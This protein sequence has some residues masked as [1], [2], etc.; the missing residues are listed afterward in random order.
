MTG[1]KNEPT[2]ALKVIDTELIEKAV[3]PSSEVLDVPIAWEAHPNAIPML[4]GLVTL[5]SRK[6]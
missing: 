2:T 6:N 5:I 3:R 4:I 1:L